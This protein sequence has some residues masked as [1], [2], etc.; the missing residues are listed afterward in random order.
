MRIAEEI[1]SDDTIL[2]GSNTG[3]NITSDQEAQ[4][5]LKNN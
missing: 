4:D 5:Y 3:W 2:E 1:G